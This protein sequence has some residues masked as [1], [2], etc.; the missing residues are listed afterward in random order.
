LGGYRRDQQV[1][2][3]LFGP[4]CGLGPDRFTL[5]LLDHRHRDLDQIADHRLYIPSDIAHLGEL[6]GLDLEKRGA[7][8]S[9][10]PSRDL[11]LADTGGPDHQDVLG[12]HLLGQLGVELLATPAVAQGDGDSSLGGVLPDDEL[13]EPGDYLPGSEIFEMW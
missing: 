1:E 5:F 10:E 3:A 7:G 12:E 8:Q 13:V 11:G 2:Q 6:A 9:G 4:F